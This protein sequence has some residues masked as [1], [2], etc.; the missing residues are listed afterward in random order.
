MLHGQSESPA[1]RLADGVNVLEGAVGVGDLGQ[2]SALAEVLAVLGQALLVTEGVDIGQDLLG[3]QTRERVAEEGGSRGAAVTQNGALAA[4]LLLA[5]AG[6]ARDVVLG[7]GLDIVVG[8]H[9]G[10]LTSELA[11]E[12]IEVD[13]SMNDSSRWDRTCL[14]PQVGRL[15]GSLSL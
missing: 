15:H 4:V 9:G 1:A 5:E 11:L 14:T 10:R 12:R 6:A 13:R 3:S 2:E 8:R 7:R